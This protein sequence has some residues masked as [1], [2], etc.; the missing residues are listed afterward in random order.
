VN[1]VQSKG[2]INMLELFIIFMLMNGLATHVIINPM[3]LEVSGRDAWISVLLTGVGY[4][5]WCVLL[6]IFMKRADKQKL[7]PWLASKTNSFVSW[8]ILIPLYLHLYFIGAETVQHTASFAQANYLPDTPSWMVSITLVIICLICAKSGLR[9]IAITAGVLL[10]IVIILGYFVSFSNMQDKDYS[11]L[12]PI[13]EKGWDPPIRGMIYA[14]S[15]MVELVFVLGLQHRLKVVPKV[16]HFLIYG[17]LTL[18]IMLGPIV[19]A[20]TEFGI[21]EAS[22]Q[23]ES[24]YEQWRLVKIGQ[25]VEHVDFLS[26]FQWLSG[27]LIRVSIVQY[28]IVELLAFT[29]KIKRNVVLYILSITYAAVAFIPI[30]RYIFYDWMLQYYVPVSFYIQ[31]IISM[32]LILISLITKQTRRRAT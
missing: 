20:I 9:T 29:N 17:I 19:G 2:I 30:N 25:M 13:L 15:G 3:L 31:F 6:A 4:L 12:K 7:Q 27:A 24:P 11:L 14:G 28:L 21:T 32:V 26:E 8:F 16:W 10:P 23:Q 1:F 5:P 22:H 18:Y